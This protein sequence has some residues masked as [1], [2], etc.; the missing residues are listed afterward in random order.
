MPKTCPS[1]YLTPLASEWDS[2]PRCGQELARGD[3]AT[4]RGKRAAIAIGV[5]ALIAG[6]AFGGAAF[7]GKDADAP[8]VEEVAVTT[9]ADPIP[10]T[11]AP[12]VPLTN[13]SM[14]NTDIA[15]EFGDSVYRLEAEGC[16]VV[17]SGSSW[18][19]DKHHLVTNWHVV[20]VDTTPT[21]IGR[22][23]SK[24][25]GEVIGGTA[26]P[27]IAVVRV[28]KPLAQPLEWAATKEL[29]E[30]QEIVGLGYPAPALDFSVTPG[31][32][33]SFQMTDGKREAIR[34]DGALDKGNS[35]GPVLTRTGQVAGVVTEMAVNDGFQ[36]VPL[37][38]TA[39]T[40]QKSVSAMIDEPQQVEPDC[41]A[42]FD[43]LPEGDWVDDLPPTADSYGDDP[44]LDELQDDCVAGDMAACDSLYWSAGFGSAYES[45]ATS[46]G[47][48]VEDPVYGMCE[49]YAEQAA[50]DA[51]AQSAVSRL[52]NTCEAGDMSACDEL[53]I[54]ADWG[55]DAYE[56]AET[57]GG[58]Y[59]D[60]YSSCMDRENAAGTVTALVAECQA[61]DM[62]ACDDL[63]WEAEYG[64]DAAEV[65][66]T[67]GGHYP[68][69]YGMCVNAEEDAQEL[70][71]YYDACAG[72]DM[73]A[74]DDL[75]LYADY[76]SQQA[77]FGSTCGNRYK[78]SYGMCEYD[79]GS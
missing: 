15:K 59:P 24:M 56:T 68:D 48:L 61:G 7:I 72:G 19:L 20:S 25:E 3:A 51:A 11:T 6:G 62:Q 49:Y 57:C 54:V 40:L 14:S 34:T 78:E 5:A 10:T 27:D 38:F 1:C 47:G 67:C 63:G 66:E 31:S 28:D 30:G 50:E 69:A 21:V 26:R 36:L 29:T 74:C 13:V 18:V 23:G 65:A 37:L 33:V 39:S 17:A 55:S 79:Y 60:G 43:V 44:A 64:S 9:T 32:I 58:H 45:V 46:C 70:Q 42:D 41:D 16:G 35:G 4:P 73:A 12:P 52:V 2:C 53:A 77:K 76:G 8:S 75:Y 22:D 71:Q